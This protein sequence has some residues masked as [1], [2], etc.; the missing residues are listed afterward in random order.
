M[1]ASNSRD[2]LI[3][4]IEAIDS[5]LTEVK[6][7]GERLSSAVRMEDEAIK[8]RFRRSPVLDFLVKAEV[9]SAVGQFEIA[10]KRVEESY[11]RETEIQLL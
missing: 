9:A 3:R 4:T 5:L 7:D 2:A 11:S 8:V 10:L 1:V 6:K